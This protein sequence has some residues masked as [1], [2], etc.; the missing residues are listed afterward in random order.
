M[1]GAV[2]GRQVR[3]AGADEIVGENAI[4]VL[5]G[6]SE[7]TPH[8]LVATETMGKH[9]GGGALA[10]KVNVMAKLGGH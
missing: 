6:G 10:G 1:A 8:R 4:P 9:H 3:A 5:V 7:V 2:I